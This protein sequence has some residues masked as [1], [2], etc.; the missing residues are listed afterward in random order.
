MDNF[1]RKLG[2]YVVAFFC[3]L[4]SAFGIGVS[5]TPQTSVPS[6]SVSENDNTIEGGEE[7]EEEISSNAQAAVKAGSNSDL[8]I[9][10]TTALTSGNSYS[11]YN[12]IFNLSSSSAVFSGGASSITMQDCIILNTSTWGLSPTTLTNVYS[13]AALT[14]ATRLSDVETKLKDVRFLAAQSYGGTSY[15]TGAWDFANTWVYVAQVHPDYSTGSESASYSLAIPTTYAYLGWT[16]AGPS[17]YYR[18]T[19]HY[20]VEGSTDAYRIYFSTSNTSATLNRG[21]IFSRPGYSNKWA[22]S[23]DGQGQSAITIASGGDIYA[24]WEPAVY[25]ISFN[26]NS[27]SGGQ[28]SAIYLKYG[29][30][31]YSSFNSTSYTV[32]GAV[33]SV[34]APTRTGYSFKGYYTASSGGT[35][36]F[37]SAG[38]LVSGKTTFTTASGGGGFGSYI[39]HQT[40]HC[41]LN[42]QHIHIQLH[43]MEMVQQVEAQQVLLQHII[44]REV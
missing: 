9:T 13:E 27:G 29:T 42:G 16:P 6:F 31:F 18:V 1:R 43:S 10:S 20:N 39:Q 14:G 28:T 21:T 19:A 40:R 17:G 26:Q 5:L 3:M 22:Y 37:N 44:L 23:A 11:F 24:I 7:Q 33:S 8:Y 15:W 30:G 12:C 36:I 41:M 32:S 34:P 2:L 4:T 35:Q 38:S 25:T